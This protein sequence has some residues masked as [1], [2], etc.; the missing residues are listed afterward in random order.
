M[1]TYTW[2]DNTMRS[3]STCDV[4]KVAD[5]LMYLKYN[6]AGIKIGTC[7]T[8]SATTEKAITLDN[9]TLTNGVTVLV[10]FT[11]ANTA[12]APT[13]NVNSTGAKAIAGEDGTVTSAT[14]PAYFPAGSTVEFVYNGTYWVFKKRVVTGYYNNGTRYR[15]YSD[16][17]KEQSGLL[18]LTPGSGNN[19]TFPV[20]FLTTYSVSLCTTDF[21]TNAFVY[22]GYLDHL[23]IST[24]YTTFVNWVV[25]GY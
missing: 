21:N 4:D 9:F 22:G 18:A 6:T 23:Q 11:S 13:L 1:T 15:V 10:T 8:V 3:G 20:P 2:T 14:H 19:V 5:N 25:T 16:G 17:F 12:T 24:S 7:S